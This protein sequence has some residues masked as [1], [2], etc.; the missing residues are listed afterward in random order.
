MICCW[1]R[2][3]RARDSFSGRKS[4]RNQKIKVGRSRTDTGLGSSIVSSEG[5][6]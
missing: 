5:R 6:Q 2:R 4:V 3:E 1:R